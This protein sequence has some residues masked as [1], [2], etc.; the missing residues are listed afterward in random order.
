MPE[1]DARDERRAPHHVNLRGLECELAPLDEHEAEER[2][3]AC[4][5]SPRRLV[6]PAA[7]LTASTATTDA[8]TT[9]TGAIE[10]VTERA[11]L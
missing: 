9:A 10:A 5:C 3:P 11:A 8:G 4:R 7:A 6:P 2:P 1:V